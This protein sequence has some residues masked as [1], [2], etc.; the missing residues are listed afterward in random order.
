MRFALIDSRPQKGWWAPGNYLNTCVLCKKEFVGDKRAGH[1]APCAYGDNK[2]H[3]PEEPAQY[4]PTTAEED[5]KALVAALKHHAGQ[6]K[7]YNCP[8]CKG[9]NCV[10][11][12]LHESSCGGYEDERN[13]CLKCGKVWWVDGI[14]S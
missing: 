1:C 5:R 9:E 7:L 6:E 2:L 4:V 8:T 14:D 3:V 13:Q 10:R 12:E 11:S